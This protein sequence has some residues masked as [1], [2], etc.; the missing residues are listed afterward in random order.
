M[1]SRRQTDIIL[2]TLN[3]MA[4]KG[5][6]AVTMKDIA[7]QFKISDAALYKHFRSKKEILAGVVSLFE[8]DAERVLEE[9]KSAESPLK[10]V[11]TFFLDRCDTFTRFPALSAVLLNNELLTDPS[12]GLQVKEMMEKHQ[13]TI[14][15]YIKKGMEKGEVR[16]DINAEHLFILFMGSLRLLIMKWKFSGY[17]INLSKEGRDLWNDLENMVQPIL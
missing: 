5:L 4:E 11:K 16:N 17:R 13:K 15:F 12:F 2:A 9:I 14:L 1:L 7:D 10:A 8:D 6:A 3:L